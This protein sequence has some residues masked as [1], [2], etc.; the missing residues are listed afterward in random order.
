[1]EHHPWGTHGHDASLQNNLTHGRSAGCPSAADAAPG[2]LGKPLHGPE[3]LQLPFQG[4]RP[5][6]KRP[7]PIAP[8]QRVH[9]MRQ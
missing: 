5:L 8:V 3:S 1:M 6:R 7:F 4:A 2:R 9:Q